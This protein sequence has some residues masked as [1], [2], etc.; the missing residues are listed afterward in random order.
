MENE[1]SVNTDYVSKPNTKI[2]VWKYVEDN[3]I[4]LL[5]IALQWN[6]KFVDVRNDD[7]TEL[8]SYACT[9]ERLDIVKLLLEFK[10]FICRWNSGHNH[11]GPLYCATKTGNI[12]IVKLL[13]DHDTNVLQKEQVNFQ[14]SWLG[15][16]IMENALCIAQQKN[17]TNIITMLSEHI[18]NQ[19][20]K[21]LE[22]NYLMLC[23]AVTQGCIL[24]VKVLLKYGANVNIK[25]NNYSAIGAAVKNNRLE[26]F[27][28][29]LE[30]GANINVEFNENATIIVA[31]GEHSYIKMMDSVNNTTST[32]LNIALDNL[33]FK[34]NKIEESKETLKNIKEDHWYYSMAVKKVNNDI[35]EL[36]DCKEIITIL[37]KI[38]N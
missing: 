37:K 26:I 7:G 19:Y 6:K 28:L 29:L 33:K 13:L 8:I 2:D 32:L 9:L 12:E 15:I 5:K 30:N 17:F 34:K 1:T 24:V 21:G 11:N 35:Q 3:S 16:N 36:A 25:K 31:T 23:G 14:P 22:V 20:I 4:Q 18:I 38:K 27:K 10:A